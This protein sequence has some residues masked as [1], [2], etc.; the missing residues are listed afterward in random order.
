MVFGDKYGRE[1]PVVAPGYITGDITSE[2][3]LLSGDVSIEKEFSAYQNK[4]EVKQEWEN[5]L[6]SGLPEDWMEYVK[7]YVKETSNEYYNLVMDRW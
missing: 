3:T 4:F 5:Q 6:N 2:Y 7:Y 1:T